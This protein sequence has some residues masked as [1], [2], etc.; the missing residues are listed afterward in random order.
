MDEHRAKHHGMGE[1]AFETYN[2]GME[3]WYDAIAALDP[4]KYLEPLPIVN[5]IIRSIKSKNIA[6]GVITDGSRESVISLH[7]GRRDYL[8]YKEQ[9]RVLIIEKIES[10]NK[11]LGVQYNRISIK[12]QKRSWGSCSR[13]RNLNFNYKILFLPERLQNYV[14]VHEL[15][16]LKEFNHSKNFWAV[17]AGIIPDHKALRKQLRRA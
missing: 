5:M 11:N 15:A 8:K 1:K 10:I 16:H 3:G 2:M 9:A 4:K 7:R 14:I 6:V 13:K 17:V 12:N